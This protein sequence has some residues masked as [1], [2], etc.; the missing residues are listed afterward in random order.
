MPK[1]KDKFFLIST[2]LRQVFEPRAC[3][4]KVWLAGESRSDYVLVTVHPPLPSDIYDTDTDLEEL[5]LATRFKGDRLPP[6]S[7]APVPVFICATKDVAN[8]EAHEFNA[9]DLILLDK[10]DVYL[11]VQDAEKNNKDH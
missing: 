8:I 3:I 7:R 6:S 2:E 9:H 5:I 11:Y 1:D 10:G 4:E